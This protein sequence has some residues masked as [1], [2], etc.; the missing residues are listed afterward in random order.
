M[1]N[2]LK[3]NKI[4]AMK[5]KNVVAKQILSLL[6]SD[7][8]SMAKKEMREVTENDIVASA[9]SLIKKNK[10]AI[11]DAKEHTGKDLPDIE[12]EIDILMGFLP[13]QI[14]EDEM[15]TTIDSLL[16][17]IPEEDR[18]RRAQGGIMKALKLKYGNSIDMGLA[19]KYVG[20]KLS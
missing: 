12:K 18:T 2:K 5:E 8:L 1:L 15:K 19:S 11:S 14:S 6:H 16:S 17:E 20:T 4:T 7:A 9:K 13:E 10:Q 3:K